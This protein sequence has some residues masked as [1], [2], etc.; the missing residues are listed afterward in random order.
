M[1]STI[2]R[3]IRFYR[4]V[5]FK[6]CANGNI[7][8]VI[9]PIPVFDHIER[10][11]H[12]ED[13]RYLG[14]GVGKSLTMKVDYISP[15]VSGRIGMRRTEAW[16]TQE[17]AGDESPIDAPEGTA[18]LESTH[19]VLFENNII[20]MEFNFHGPRPTALKTYVPEKAPDR[21]DAMEMSLILNN[22]ARAIISK[23]GEIRMA[24]IAVS[25]NSAAQLSQLNP[26]LPNALE[27][28]EHYSP[29]ADEY[30]LVLKKRGRNGVLSS[31]SD[32]ANFASWIEREENRQITRKLVLRGRSDETGN[33]EDF[34]LLGDSLVFEVEASR[35]DTEHNVVN[36]DS[37]YGKIVD[38]YNSNRDELERIA[39]QLA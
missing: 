34:D 9:D 15:R 36:S 14:Y 16:P 17:Q 37:M 5:L 29:E 26:H 1:S 31:L 8:E 35:V 24:R 33:L 18:L 20:G 38:V 3:K 7:E 21:V 6:T 12:D 13:G 39:G 28:L 2:K 19:F 32:L 23:I 30:E 11:P 4:Y 10:L 27:A 22:D 25:G